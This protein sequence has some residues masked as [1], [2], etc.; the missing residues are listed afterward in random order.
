MPTLL[1]VWESRIGI[2][3]VAGAK[4]NPIILEWWK[5]AGHPEIID[6]ETA[7]C[8]GSMCSAAKEA[9]LPFPPV[10]VNPMARSWLTWGKK[11]EPAEVQPGDVTIWPRGN[12]AGPYAHVNC[13][14]EVR[15]KNKRI[16]VRCIGGN[17]SHPSG[18]A[19]TLTDWI[20]VKGAL[21]NGVRR[22][23][24]ATVPELRKAGSSEIKKADRVQNAGSL[25]TILA[26]IVA[27]VK[28]LFGPVDVPKFADL[29]EGLDWWQTILGG[30][31]AVGRL[32]LDNPWL[33]G[34]LLVGGILILVGRQIKAARI[35]KHEA[36]V[37][38]SAEVSKLQVA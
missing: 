1:E 4:N 5:D 18:G 34:T 23:V 37:P 35:A 12:P 14:K 16:E 21:P 9:G 31:N 15:K 29:K 27:A 7:W 30:A 2:A 6:D 32:F 13:V 17:Q 33:G 10:N 26:A 22:A 11:V 20:D 38:L 3:E 24:P 8:S 36:G 25:L 28:D 19:V